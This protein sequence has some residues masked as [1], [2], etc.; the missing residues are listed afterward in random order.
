MKL[1]SYPTSIR[2]H[3]LGPTWWSMLLRCYHPSCASY[4]YYGAKGITVCARWRDFDTFLEDMGRRPT[5]YT[6]DRINVTEG[7]SPTNCRWL[8]AVLN[9]TRSTHYGNK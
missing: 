6:L 4:K 7:Y 2:K 3:P 8:P 1:P 9:H 5:G